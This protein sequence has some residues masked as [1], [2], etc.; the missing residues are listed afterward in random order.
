LIEN[1]DRLIL[2]SRS[3]MEQNG[4]ECERTRT[5]ELASEEAYG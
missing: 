3:R 4:A 5:S 2:T 1:N